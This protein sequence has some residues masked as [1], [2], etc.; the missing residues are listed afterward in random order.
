MARFGFVIVG[1]GVGSG[2]GSPVSG[3]GRAIARVA[4]R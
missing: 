2:V 3:A 4:D 1:V